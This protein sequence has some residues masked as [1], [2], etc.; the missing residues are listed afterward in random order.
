MGLINEIYYLADCI[1]K[2]QLEIEKLYEINDQ[3]QLD[4]KMH[5]LFTLKSRLTYLEKNA[6]LELSP[7]IESD[8]ID[9]YLINIHE[10]KNDNPE[11]FK[12]NITLHNTKKIIGN[13]ELRFNLLINELYLG[14]LGAYIDNEYRGMRISKQAFLLL[15][16]TM[17]ERGVRKPI[18]TVKS[19]NEKS[20][21][22]LS[23]IGAK[24]KDE[25]IHDGTIYYS[26]EY[27]LENDKRK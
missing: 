21:K 20:I 27:D 22:S 23:N 4:N 19:D 18:F 12:Y 6:Y 5:E 1:D 10:A 3:V 13:I 11:I 8:L 9:L 25:F 14:N 15:K 26:Y 17:L 2:I 16:D 24:Y 7:T